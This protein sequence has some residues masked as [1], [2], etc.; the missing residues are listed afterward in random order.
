M[1]TCI[2]VCREK[3]IRLIALGS[4]K[5]AR[6]LQAPEVQTRHIEFCDDEGSRVINSY[7]QGTWYYD[8]SDWNEPVQ[9]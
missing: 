9:N 1:R 4:G 8:R 6:K 7:G 5:F 2:V 3:P